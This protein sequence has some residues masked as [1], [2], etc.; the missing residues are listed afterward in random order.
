MLFTLNG[1]VMEL[2]MIMQDS[3]SAKNDFI[4][5]WGKYTPAFVAGTQVPTGYGSNIP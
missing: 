2:Q 4:N 5:T 3:P 1:T